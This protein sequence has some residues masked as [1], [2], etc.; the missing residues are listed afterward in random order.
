MHPYCHSCA[1]RSDHKEPGQV[2]GFLLPSRGSQES[3]PLRR[4]F[5]ACMKVHCSQGSLREGLDTDKPV[6]QRY[7]KTPAARAPLPHHAVRVARDRISETDAMGRRRCE[8]LWR[9][10]RKDE[11]TYSGPLH[12]PGLFRV[13]EVAPN[14]GQSGLCLQP[15][16][17]AGSGIGVRR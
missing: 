14:S 2:P 17:K 9:T 3:R 7:G 11:R 12:L 1:F 13:W 4:V 10:A 5:C 15:R 16:A 8:C 6:V